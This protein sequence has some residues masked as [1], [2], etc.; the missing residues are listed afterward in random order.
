MGKAIPIQCQVQQS[1]IPHPD[2]RCTCDVR[3]P[4]SFLVLWRFWSILAPL[5][6]S[7]GANTAKMDLSGFEEGYG[8]RLL[9][10]RAVPSNKT[11][12]FGIDALPLTT[13]Q[14]DQRACSNFSI[15]ADIVRMTR[16]RAA[17]WLRRA[18]P[19]QVCMR[20]S[21]KGLDLIGKAASDESSQ[22]S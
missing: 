6:P 7:R 2:P 3:H 14:T 5:L 21:T 20:R 11:R 4:E 9:V 22:L 8:E 17:A 1:I 19:R 12:Q 16:R 18:I 10:L 15:S 13:E